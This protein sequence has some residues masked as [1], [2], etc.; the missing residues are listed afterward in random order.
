MGFAAE[1]AVGGIGGI[2]GSGVLVRRLVASGAVADV[3]AMLNLDV[4]GAG[5]E[6]IVAIGS[7]IFTFPTVRIANALGIPARVGNLP[8]NSGSD[9]ANF[10][11][12]GIPVIFPTISGAAIHVASD[13]FD[14]IDSAILNNVGRTAHALL[15]CL[16]VGN[17]APQEA[18]EGCDLGG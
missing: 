2:A 16:L 7:S 4:S 18:P 13:N 15:Q 11:A 17:G 3:Y 14:N 9:H 5:N 8:A 12:V 1:E 6:S 10:E